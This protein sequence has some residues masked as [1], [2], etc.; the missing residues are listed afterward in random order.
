VS[1]KEEETGELRKLRNEVF[2]YQHTLRNI[3]RVMKSRKTRWARRLACMGDGKGAYCV[4][5]GRPE[6]R[7]P[8]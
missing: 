5:V 2:C 8:P 1:K 6:E 3:S 7:P 4:L